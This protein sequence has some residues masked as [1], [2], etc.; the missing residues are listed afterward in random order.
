MSIDRRK[1]LTARVGF[2]I[3]E[4][5]ITMLGLGVKVDGGLKFVIAVGE[6]V[7]WPIPPTGSTNTHGRFNMERAGGIEP[8]ALAWEKPAAQTAFKLPNYNMLRWLMLGIRRM[9]N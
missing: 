7:C 9:L 6:S 4:G 8:P 1:R 5:P 3:K 2:R